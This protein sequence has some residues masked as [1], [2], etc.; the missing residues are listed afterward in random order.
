MVQN[1]KESYCFISTF[2]LRIAIPKT[3]V[4]TATDRLAQTI[5]K[6]TPGI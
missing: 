5:L 6:P 2:I 1:D 3:S 4:L